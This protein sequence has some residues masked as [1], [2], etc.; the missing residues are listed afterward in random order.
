M[1]TLTLS[2]DHSRDP[3]NPGD[4]ADDIAAALTL[5]TPPAVGIDQTSIT[6]NHPNVTETNRAAIEAVIGSYVLDPVRAAFPDGPVGTLLKKAHTAIQ[7]NIDALGLPDPTDANNAYLGHAAIPA[8]TLTATQLSAIIR[9]LSDQLD[10]T[11]RQ[12]NALIAQV[13]A[14]TKQ[15]TA[16]LRITVGAVDQLA[17]T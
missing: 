4:L 17:G 3:M 12:N 10:A 13:R 1:A 8:G 14:L 11:T 5:G 2:Y 6:V 7:T 15:T 16:I 9:T